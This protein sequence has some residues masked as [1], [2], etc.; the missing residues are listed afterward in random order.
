MLDDT[1]VQLRVIVAEPAEQ[2]RAGRTARALQKEAEVTAVDR[3][4]RRR[5]QA[6]K[7]GQGV[8]QRRSWL[9]RGQ[10]IQIGWLQLDGLLAVP[11]GVGEQTQ[12][13]V[14]FDAPVSRLGG[15]R[16]A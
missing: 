8:W 1:P 4:G 3:L 10:C 16:G 13:D 11:H 12:A 15:R 5:S 14:V 6:G 9:E 7:N 2:P